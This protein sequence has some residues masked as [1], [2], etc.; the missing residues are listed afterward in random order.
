MYNKV[1]DCS[2]NIHMNIYKI[3]QTNQVNF[4]VFSDISFSVTEYCTVCKVFGFGSLLSCWF[5]EWVV[6]AGF[7]L[8]TKVTKW[9]RT[10]KRSTNSSSHSAKNKLKWNNHEL[11]TNSLRPGKEATSKWVISRKY[12]KHE[13]L[14]AKSLLP[15][16][17]IL[18]HFSDVL[19][20]MSTND[21]K[22]V[23]FNISVLII[24]LRNVLNFMDI[25]ILFPALSSFNYVI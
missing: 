13:C 4:T 21:F 10:T 24:L 19:W 15:P 12:A 20:G 9:T 7:N 11:L 14:K 3:P 16:P 5:V 25:F 18:L 17:K 2:T 22:I 6:K 1:S 23:A 8:E